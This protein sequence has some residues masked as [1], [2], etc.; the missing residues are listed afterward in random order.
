HL[1]IDC[2]SIKIYLASEGLAVRSSPR[3]QR[4]PSSK[5]D[6]TVDPPC[7]QSWCTLNLM[8]WVKSL[9][10]GVVRKFGQGGISSGVALGL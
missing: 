2:D 6:F 9:P 10:T 8:S 4:V 7:K 5:P 3:G 1:N